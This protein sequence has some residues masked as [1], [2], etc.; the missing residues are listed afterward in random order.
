MFGLRERPGPGRVP[1]SSWDD[2]DN[3]KMRFCYVSE[4]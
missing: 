2:S 3:K 1:I 4:F